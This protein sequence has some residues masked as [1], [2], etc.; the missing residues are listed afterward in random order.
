MQNRFGDFIEIRDKGVT[1]WCT[2]KHSFD[3]KNIEEELRFNMFMDYCDRMNEEIKM[4]QKY[5]KEKRKMNII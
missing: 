1:Y 4:K 5:I 3:N 2:S